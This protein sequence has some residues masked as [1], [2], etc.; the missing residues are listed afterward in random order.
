MAQLTR[1][2]DQSQVRVQNAEHLT[3]RLNEIDGILPAKK[4][5]G[6]TR[7]AYHLYMLRYQADKF[8]GLPREKFL[9]AL[10]EEGIPGWGGYG[11]K[12]GTSPLN[13][14]PFIENS[15]NSRGFREIY[16]E[17]RIR[18]YIEKNHCPVNNKLCTEA[19]WFGQ[20]MFLGTR[21][22]MDQIADAMLKIQAH[23]AELAKA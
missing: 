7:H 1:F 18:D 6:C 15:L 8:A 16:S 13:L 12:N 3:N 23:A 4:Y 20:S 2:E 17:E 10:R 14:E 21:E 9:K 11:G 22:D 5:E 19:I